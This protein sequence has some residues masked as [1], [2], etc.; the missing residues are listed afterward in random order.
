MPKLHRLRAPG[1]S[2]NENESCAD[3]YQKMTGGGGVSACMDFF[4]RTLVVNPDFFAGAWF[5]SFAFL[6]AR[7]IFLVLNFSLHVYCVFCYFPTPPPSRHFSTGPSSH[8]PKIKFDGSRDFRAIKS[9]PLKTIYAVHA[10]IVY[11]LSS[12]TLITTIF[13]N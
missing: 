7:V 10:R 4:F 8:F 3:G 6:F 9:R 12:L 2:G 1:G 5:F 11:R 13:L